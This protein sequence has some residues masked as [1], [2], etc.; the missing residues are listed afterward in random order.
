[1]EAI[2][3]KLTVVSALPTRPRPPADLGKPEAHEW[4][5]IVNQMPAPY[6]GRETHALL[7]Q[8]CRIT[9]QLTKI[10]AEINKHTDLTTKEFATLVKL[11]ALQSKSLIHIAAKL[12]C[13]QSARLLPSNA[14]LTR[15]G[16]RL[17]DR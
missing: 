6:F 11:Q 15:I 2:A 7:A 9:V 3:A 16:P 4:E 14:A 13:C 17:W 12:R 5:S 10:A 1:M 8:Y